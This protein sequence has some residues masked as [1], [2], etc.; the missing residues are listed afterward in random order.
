MRKF[1][2]LCRSAPSLR[3]GAATLDQ[4]LSSASNFALIL[5]LARESS[6]SQFGQLVIAYA[7]LTFAV[8]ISRSALG[9]ILG[10]DLPAASRR[11]GQLLIN[12]SVAAAVILGLLPFAALGTWALALCVTGEVQTASILGLLAVA[13]PLILLQ[14]TCRYWAVAS[15]RPMVAVRADAIWVAACVAPFAAGGLGLN[16][17]AF[18]GAAAWVLG[19]TLSMVAFLIHGLRAR[20]MWAGLWA[21]FLADERRRH[22]G[23]DAMLAAFAPLANSTGA[24]F[25]AGPQVT[26]AVRGAGTLFGPLNVLGAA[27]ALAVVPEA[28]RATPRRARRM[29]IILAVTLATTAATTGICLSLLPNSLGTQLLG[30]TWGPAKG[31]IFLLALEYVGLGLWTAAMM[32]FRAHGAT[33][34]ALKFRSLYAFMSIIL[35]IAAVGVFQD[36]RAFAAVLAGLGLL[37]GL[38]S[39]AVALRKPVY[40]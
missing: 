37:L 29:V 14:D 28:R 23:A 18:T 16:V 7:S 38:G 36:A 5:L 24:A 15:A 21:W 1:Q 19:A 17:S 40:D 9:V 8:T 11:D 10:I 3:L 33:G 20:P 26:A 39:L 22:L 13:S 25:V 35:P 2:A 4:V 30:P 31:L 6:P 32:H 12:R 27:V 34:T